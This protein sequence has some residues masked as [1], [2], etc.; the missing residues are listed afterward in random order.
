[1]RKKEQIL[2][3]YFGVVAVETLF[4]IAYLLIMPSDPKNVILWGFSIRRII[5]ILV[6]L[7]ICI[8][9]F[10]FSWWTWRNANRANEIIK[11]WE[12]F[13]GRLF[14]L[15]LLFSSL[16][17]SG[18][19]LSFTSPDQFGEA[20][21]YIEPLRPV[22]IWMTLVGF[23]T[24]MPIM[25]F[26]NGFFWE[27]FKES[28]SNNRHIFKKILLVFI[29]I[30]GTWGFMAC[31]GIGII[32]DSLYWRNPGTPILGSQIFLSLCAGIGALVISSLSK[33]KLSP[34]FEMVICVLIWMI[35]A[36]LWVREPQQRTF[37]SPG[38]YPPNRSYYPFSDAAG[39]DLSAQFALIGQGFSN[40]KNVDKPLLSAFILVLHFIAGQDIN[41]VINLQVILFAAFPVILYLLGRNIHSRIAGL[42]LAF[43]AIFK[44]MNAIASAGA[45]FN[46]NSKLILSEIPLEI[47][48]ALLTFCLVKWLKSSG[49]DYLYILAAGGLLGFTTLI[50]HNTWGLFPGLLLLVFWVYRRQRKRLALSILGVLFALSA[51]L[52]P[53]FWRS[54]QVLGYPFYFYGPMRSV[55]YQDRYTPSISS[56]EELLLEST[57][58]PATA[59][60][61]LISTPE[62]QP[63]SQPSVNWVGNIWE[64]YRG[65]VQFVSSHF[66]H[67]LVSTTL[68]LPSRLEY[69][70][71]S[72]LV[73]A[74]GSFWDPNWDGSLSTENAI[75]ISLNL[76][77]VAIGVGFAWARWKLAGLM[78]LVIS[79]SY[80]FTTALARTSGG[81]Y[82]VPADWVVYF[83][84]GLGIAEL[85]VW[86]AMLFRYKSNSLELLT[87]KSPEELPVSK[88]QQRFKPVVLFMILITFGVSIPLWE[89][90]LPLR[91]PEQINQEVYAQ[92]EME[93][94]LNDLGFPKED[95]RTFIDQVD[96]VLQRGMALSPRFYGVKEGETD[97]F[98]DYRVMGFPRLV[99]TL[100]N[101][102]GGEGVILPLKKSMDT[103]TNGA[104]IIVLGC[105]EKK[106]IR[107][108][109]IMIPDEDLTY[110]RFPAA[111][112]SCP[113]PDPV[114][115]D[116]R[117]CR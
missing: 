97:R 87:Q 15:Q 4:L 43:L 38:P 101:I 50:R 96:A 16:I 29:I 12:D 56:E 82:I 49:N 32:K 75:L 113:I 100:I 86:I 45:I 8:L 66:F 111:T 6:E 35:A 54:Y 77:L 92:L 110:R 74:P 58:V 26:R 78:P 108:L 39:Y 67:G 14:I 103:F 42:I 34:K 104:S 46:S 23:Q 11:R 85:I 53:W 91:F 48:M 2:P 22:F 106:G 105:R 60:T 33:K 25:I 99:I 94:R 65:V 114:C 102:K 90:L 19:I 79:V 5:I 73:K 30:L 68:M 80:L 31:T 10:R 95:I 98:S 9:Y 3:L 55:V 37:F 116:N 70:D 84:F 115:D 117:V 88:L 83:Y 112:L 63:E 47:V 18:W 64:R 52:I 81:R 61:S 40:G 109:A 20:S 7:S 1:M 72:A 17:I 69:E 93:G 71:I 24:L 27:S 57:Q 28:V 44:E 62:A 21:S 59:P 76:A 41:H 13:R 107:A 51:V 89:K 36:F